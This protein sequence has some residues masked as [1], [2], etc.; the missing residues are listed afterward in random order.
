MAIKYQSMEEPQTQLSAA[1]RAKQPRESRK[2]SG[3]DCSNNLI[4]TLSPALFRMTFLTHLYLDHNRIDDLPPDIDRLSNLEVLDLSYNKLHILPPE[5]GNVRTLKELLLNHN[6]LSSLPYEL[7]RLFRVKVLTLSGNPLS[8]PL[9]SMSLTQDSTETILLYLLDNAPVAPSPPER[10]WLTPNNVDLAKFSLTHKTFSVFCYNILCDKYAT[11]QIYRYCPTWALDWEYRR[12]NIVREIFT[13]SADIISLQEVESQEF[14][15]YFLP[16][17]LERGYNGIFRAKS[18]ARTMGEQDRKFVDGCAIFYNMAK[19]TLLE[20]HLIEF[21]RLASKTHAGC[22]DMLNRVMPKDQVALVALLELNNSGTHA[23]PPDRVCVVNAHLAWEPIFKDVKVIQ[24]VL[25]VTEVER[26]LREASLPN[27]P[28]LFTGDLNSL[29]DSGVYA[30]MDNG[31]THL[32]HSDFEGRDYAAFFQKTSLRHGFRL[33]SAYTGE[34]P[35]TN[36]TSDFTGIIDYIWYTN[37]KLVPTMILGPVDPEYMKHVD[38]CPNPHFPS[39]HHSL[40][41]EFAILKK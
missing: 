15:A 18:R 5:L 30:Y 29:P 22:A 7:G 11:R 37:D 4:L 41:C 27:I 39:D 23:T 13:R 32:S 35:F 31:H 36:Y 9:M 24:S 2:F 1:E 16:Q 33:S 40:L 20:D 25:M 21:E 34:M 26:I 12:Q 14:S 3:I 8:E 17:L 10:V 19:F 38:G 6:Q 28:T